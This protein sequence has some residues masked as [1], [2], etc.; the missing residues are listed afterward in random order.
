MEKALDIIMDISEQLLLAGAEISRV[1]ESIQHLGRAFG[2]SRTDAF[3]ITSNME[4]SL[5]NSEGMSFTQ[6][7]R[8]SNIGA[9]IERLHRLN[10]LIRKICANE[11]NTDEISEKLDKITNS[12]SYPFSIIVFA[13]GLVSGAFALF[14]GGNAVEAVCSFIIGMILSFIVKVT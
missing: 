7:R 10:G 11:I 12:K 3:I 2:A 9:D 4:V 8:V 13:Y 6:T 1:E 14:F 5:H